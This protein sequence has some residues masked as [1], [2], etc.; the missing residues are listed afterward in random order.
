MNEKKRI[1]EKAL[2]HIEDF[3]TPQKIQGNMDLI[4]SKGK[5]YFRCIEE[6]C[7]AKNIVVSLDDKDVAI[8][9]KKTKC[10]N[11]NNDLAMLTARESNLYK[12]GEVYEPLVILDS[13]GIYQN[14]PLHRK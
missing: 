9:P 5:N 8:F 11:C 10:L 4:L 3:N 13:K 1:M 7:E 6:R 14:N 12:P 2:G